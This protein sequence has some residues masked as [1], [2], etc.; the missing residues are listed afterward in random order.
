M[1][2]A[3]TWHLLAVLVGWHVIGARAAFAERVVLDDFADLAGWTAIA[4]EG[5]HVWIARESDETGTGMRIGF[6]LN[7]GG[8]WVIVRKSFSLALPENYAFSFRLR[9]ETRPNNFEFKLV[10]PRGKNVW[11]RNQRDY[12]FPREWQRMTIRKSRLDFAWGPAGGGEPK[13]VGAIELAISAGEGGSGSIWIGDLGFE[14]REPAGQDG[15]APAAQA[16]TFLPGHEPPLMLDQDGATAWKSA[17]LPR[18]QWAMIDFGRN[19]EYGGL[20]I[21]WDA[22]DYAVAFEVQ[23]S[24]DGSAWTTAYRTATGHGGRDYI[25][26]PDAESRFIRLAMQR[27]SRGRGYGIV[28]LAVKPFEFSAS[29]NQFFGAIARD[30]PAGTYPKY[31][32]GKQTYWTEVGVEG[33]DKQAILN[34]EGMLEVEKGAFSIEPF[35]YTD[36]GLVTWSAAR[37]EQSLEDGYLPIPSVTWRHNRLGLRVTAFATGEAGRSTLLARYR[38]ENHGDDGEPVQL[39]L[40]IRPFQVSPPWQSLNMTGGVTHI[41]EMRFDGRTVWVNRDKAV[42]SITPTDHFGAGTFEEGSVTQFLVR[43]KVPPQTDVSDPF[44]FASGALQY[45]FYL[46]PRAHAEVDLAVP[47]HDARVAAAGLGS[48]GNAA[49]VGERHEEAR[50]HWQNV[51]DRVEIALPP[52]AE[53]IVRTLKTT[54]AYILINRDGPALRPGSRNY[55]RSWIRDGALTSVALLQLGTV[56]EV[57]HFLEWYARYQTADGKVPCCVDRRGADPVVENDSPGAFIF[58][59]A[60]YYRFT[61]DVGFLADMWPRV[62]RAVDYLSSLRKRRMTEEFRAPDKQALYGLLPESIS[63]EGYAAHPVH[64]YWDDFFALRGLKDAAALAIVVGDEDH[65]T[66]F[67]ALRDA[68]RESLYTSIARTVADHGIDYIPGSVELGDFDPTSTAIAIVP[69]GELGNLPE[70]AL[71]R[72]FD[73]YWEEFE[74]RKDGASDSDAYTPY[75]IRNVG[76]FVRLGQRERALALLDWFLADRRPVGWNEWAEIAWRDPTA[77]RFIGD[78]P[79]TWVGAGYIRSVRSLFAYER[80]S[81]GTLVLAAGVPAAWVR[82]EPGVVVKRL[83]THYGVLNYTLRAEGPDAVRFRLSGDL[84]VPPGKIVVSSPLGRPL[85]SVKVN[86]KSVDTF[87]ADGAVITECPADVVLGYEP[88][89][90]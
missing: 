79:H 44:G 11:W 88:G 48:D 12:V 80:E 86:G 43:G 84:A 30:A 70:P 61:H 21:D 19:R 75:E 9:G 71:S 37:T 39:F 7:I 69:G 58:G 5:T 4:S 66:K 54:L 63:H 57:R 33:D 50:R 2:A 59:I 60:E 78:M 20:V 53:K 26:M 72:T 38:V 18:E 6:D 90:T 45:N 47:W 77:P 55:A 14:T 15:V 25:Y 51:L 56:E 3:R 73:R 49:W 29:A 85:R 8:G 22:D 17:P 13:Q 74:K 28:A 36:G 41:Q 67:A 16:S 89:S 87:T 81:D 46:E 27:S 64:S 35:L 82:E 76:T 42:V 24:S 32:Y 31:L 62:V 34:E 68:F 23:V 83:P 52:S 10:D 1:R 65:A 40:A